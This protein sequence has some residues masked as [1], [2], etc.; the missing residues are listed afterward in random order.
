MKRLIYCMAALGALIFAASC[1]EDGLDVTGKTTEVTFTVAAPSSIYSKAVANFANGES[2]IANG[3]N[4][5]SLYYAI[6]GGEDFTKLLGKGKAEGSVSEGKMTFTVTLNLVIDQ[7]YSIIFWAHTNGAGE[8]Y[9][10]ISD[11]TKVKIRN[12]YS[13]FE[14]N[15]EDRAAFYAHYDITPT[16]NATPQTVTLKRPFAQLNLGTTTLE[17]SLTERIQVQTTTVTVKNVAIANAFNTVEGIG[18]G[19][20]NLTEVTFVA[21]S[22]PHGDQ[23]NETI[24]NGGQL[25]KVKNSTTGEYDTYHWIGM[26]Y[27]IAVGGETD[28]VTSVDVDIQTNAGQVKHTVTNVPLR[29]NYRTNLL[30]NFLTTGVDFNIIVEKMFESDEDPNDEKE[31]ENIDIYDPNHKN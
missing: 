27:L 28:T 6:Y 2:T 31:D 1:A 5:D 17:S 21:A 12:N 23:D 24:E 9:Y 11:L 7:P 13:G 25:L 15:D 20:S 30:G 14:A 22:T 4:T 26:N 8:K 16:V 18:E 3:Q 29:Q 10:D 19:D